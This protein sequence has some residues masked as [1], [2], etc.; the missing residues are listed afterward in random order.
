MCSTVIFIHIDRISIFIEYRFSILS[1]D[2]LTLIAACVFSLLLFLSLSLDFFLLLD[3]YYYY[4]SYYI[5]L[6]KRIL[7]LKCT[8]C[9]RDHDDVFFSL[10]SVRA[11]PYTHTWQKSTILSQP[12]LHTFVTYFFSFDF[13]TVRAFYPRK[14]KYIILIGR[15]TKKALCFLGKYH[16]TG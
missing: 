13:Y 5:L 11:P 4:Y 9:A 15:V 1:Y 2:S 10:M 16:T 12:H 3:Y 6:F 14:I 7:S 8:K